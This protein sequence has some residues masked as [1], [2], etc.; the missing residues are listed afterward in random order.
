MAAFFT[1]AHRFTAAAAT[2]GGGGRGAP[3][4]G[5]E[6]GASGDSGSGGVVSEPSHQSVTG[7]GATARAQTALGGSPEKL[8]T[9]V[10][11]ASVA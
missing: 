6:V 11:R 4:P 2:D 7:Q 1:S 3:P 10:D 5:H 9:D 8:P